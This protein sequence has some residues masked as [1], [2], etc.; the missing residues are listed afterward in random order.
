MAEKAEGHEMTN[1]FVESSPHFKREEF[2]CKFTNL[3]FMDPEAVDRLEKLRVEFGKPITLSSAYRDSSHPAERTKKFPGYHGKGMAYDIL[4]HGE[5]AVRIL[6]LALKYG[7]GGIG[8]NQKG[9]YSQR[10]IHLDTRDPKE[11]RI[12]SY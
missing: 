11:T 7:Y 5:D 12:W 6:E 3:C 1:K 2:A 9:E 10:F 8:V 4:V